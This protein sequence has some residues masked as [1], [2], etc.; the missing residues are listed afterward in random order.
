MDVVDIGNVI[1]PEDVALFD[2]SN[3]LG[4]TLDDGCTASLTVAAI[5]PLA[6]GTAG[7]TLGTTLPATT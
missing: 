1:E 7:T 4:R 2:V 5:K 3:V 6:W